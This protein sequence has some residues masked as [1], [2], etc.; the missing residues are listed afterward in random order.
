MIM[1]GKVNN[2]NQ[3]ISVRKVIYDGGKADGKR[4]IEVDNGCISFCLLL[5]NGFDVDYLRHKGE[6]VS[7]ISKNGLCGFNDK[8]DSVFNGGMLYTCGLDT[9]GGRELPIHGRY[10]NIPADLKVLECDGENFKAVAEVE[11]NGLFLD[12]LLIK[13]T[14]ETKYKSGKIS[15]KTEVINNGYK[16]AEYALLFHMNLGYPFL[17]EGVKIIAPIEKTVP[18]TDYAKQKIKDCLVMEETQADI[19]ET[20]FYHK[21]NNGNV[22]VVNEKLKRSVEFIYD[23][24]AL[25]H[26]IE[27]KSMICGD[28]ALGIEPSTTTLDGDFVKK[29]ISAGETHVYDISIEVKDI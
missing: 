3:L 18:R 20:V 24:K 2:F 7:F 27:W 12:N 4:A 11:H 6:N 14:V 13:R 29:Q 8:F 9:V 25:P 19:E 10:H 28:Y 1:N 26:F 17:D 15:I 23:E 16:N 5:D 22:L 21:V